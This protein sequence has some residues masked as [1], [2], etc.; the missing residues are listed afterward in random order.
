[1]GKTVPSYRMALEN[2]IYSWISFAKTL[3]SK[4]DIEAFEQVIDATRNCAMAAGNAC[5]PIVFEAMTMSIILFQQ[6]KINNFERELER[7]R[8]IKANP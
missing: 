4:Q 7:L 8:H 3:P 2:E 5:R 6:K 1:M